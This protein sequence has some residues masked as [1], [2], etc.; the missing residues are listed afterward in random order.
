M[1]NCFIYLFIYFE[2]SVTIPSRIKKWTRKMYSAEYSEHLQYVYKY[3]CICR[4]GFEV[5]NTE[6]KNEQFLHK[7]ILLSF[8]I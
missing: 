3:N 6:K 2:S 1:S 8:D 4:L 5:F 7:T